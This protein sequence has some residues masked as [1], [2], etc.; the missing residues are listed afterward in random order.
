MTGNFYFDGISSSVLGV[1][2][3]NIGSSDDTMPMFG[4]QNFTLQNVIEHEYGTFIRA[5]KDIMRLTLTFMIIDPDGI[6]ANEAL[7][8]ARLNTLAKFFMRSVPVEFM[9]EEDTT[10]VIRLVPT[11]AIDVVR[12]GQMRG[13]FQ[14]T[15]QATTPYWMTPMEVLTFNLN[16]GGSFAVV[17]R[18]NIQDKHGNFDVYPRIIIHNMAATP[19]FI[20]NNTSLRGRQVGFANVATGERIEMHHRIVRAN[21]NANIFHGWNKEPFFLVENLNTLTVNSGCTI[22]IHVQYPTF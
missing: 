3:V 16:A 17:N 15:F 1:Q 5:R 4:G 6:R 10:K 9:A 20:L 7:T 22:T 8:A 19:N 14:I 12:F 21:I 2:I 18:R 11:S 13:F